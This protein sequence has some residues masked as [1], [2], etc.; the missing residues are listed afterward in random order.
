M[1]IEWHEFLDEVVKPARRNQESCAWLFSE[2]PLC[3]DDVIH[4]VEV[5][6]VGIK[7]DI[8]NSFAP[9]KKEFAKVKAMAK[10]SGYTRIGNVH[11]HNVFDKALVAEQNKPSDT[12]LKFARRFNDIIRGIVVVVFPSEVDQDGVIEEIVWHNQYGDR[13]NQNTLQIF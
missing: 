4:V 6:N 2:K 5:S 8:T 10:K 9:N 3:S 11:T 12:D 1:R 13:L 7:G